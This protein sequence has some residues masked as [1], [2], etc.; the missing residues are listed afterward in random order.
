MS[1]PVTWPTSSSEVGVNNFTV[2]I[3]DQPVFLDMYLKFYN[4][5]KNISSSASALSETWMVPLASFSFKP[6]AQRSSL[7]CVQKQN[8]ISLPTKFPFI[9]EVT[10]FNELIVPWRKLLGFEPDQWSVSLVSS[11]PAYI[12]LNPQH[13]VSQESLP[14]KEKCI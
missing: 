3:W 12:V 13:L 9:A 2:H 14:I 8:E 1:A 4:I 11:P 5:W 7:C 6:S 10:S